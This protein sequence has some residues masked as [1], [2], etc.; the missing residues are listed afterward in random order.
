MNDTTKE[1]QFFDDKGEIR[2]TVRLENG[3][4][5]FSAVSPCYTIKL[6][7]SDGTTEIH[8]GWQE[9]KPNCTK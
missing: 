7:D 1:V 2:A 8:H 3:F 6:I 5:N 9:H 4:V